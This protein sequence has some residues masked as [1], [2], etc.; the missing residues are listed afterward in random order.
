MWTWEG[1]AGTLFD[2]APN[3]LNLL[4]LVLA[5]E[6]VA[7]HA[8]ALRGG[9]LPSALQFFAS[10][11]GVDSFFAISGFLICRAWLRRPHLGR[12]LLARARRLLPG[13]WVCLAA[14][15]F[16]IAPL[17][18]AIA[19]KPIPGLGAS[20]NYLMNNAA[21]WVRDWS[22]EGSPIGLSDPSW[23]GS[24]WT[25]SWEVFCYLSIAML[26]CLKLLRPRIVLGLAIGFWAYGFTLDMVGVAPVSG[27]IW[28]WEPQ[29]AGVM[30]FTGAALWCY[31][32]VIRIDAR[33]ALLSC[34]L[35]P[36][37][38][39][40]TTNYRVVAAPAITYLCIFAAV[41][42]GRYPWA[43]LRHDLSYGVYI[44]SFPIQQALILCGLG[45]LAWPLFLGV[46]IAF[47][48]PTA[49]ASWFVVEQPVMRWRRGQGARPGPRSW[50]VS[51]QGELVVGE[52][53]SKKPWPGKAV[54]SVGDQATFPSQSF[55]VVAR[56]PTDVS[57]VGV[58][59]AL[60]GT[61]EKHLPAGLE[62]R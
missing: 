48:V 2:R 52:E 16:V 26:G 39:A 7:W 59:A 23:N 44:Y 35:I 17:A 20:F 38:I 49:A 41:A 30:F 8:C 15:A 28:L 61:D 31:R 11:I 58:I 27:S 5:F 14:T 10:D 6:V 4:R 43:V 1:S 50:L 33:L 53:A 25:L 57:V 54:P 19:G 36:L 12:Y 56:S 42:L 22:I 60:L 24:L 29:R 51:E 21:V 37:S 3:A 32:E 9:E 62:G 46:S 45:T 34:A 18:C 47:I 13:L 40:I 55:Q